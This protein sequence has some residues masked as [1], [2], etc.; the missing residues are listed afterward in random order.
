MTE[1][2]IIS[3]LED[4]DARREDTELSKSL[5]KYFNTSVVDLF[6]D[7]IFSSQSVFLI[8]NVWGR[9][10][11]PER[12]K[13]IYESLSEGNIAYL[14]RFDGKGDQKGKRY[15]IELYKDY[16]HQVVPTYNNV[17][18][19]LT[20][21]FVEYLLKPIYGGSGKGIIHVSAENLTKLFDDQKYLIQ[22]KLDFGSEL[23]LFFVDDTFQYALKTKNERW[24]LE[25]YTPTQDELNTAELFVRWNPIRGIQR[26]D[27][28]KT[29]D[30]HSLLLEIEDWCPYLS[31]GD[32]K[33]IPV[34]QFVKSIAE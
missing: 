29:K 33:N 23:S 5:G 22:P 13:K 1:L 14:N 11:S 12:M 26:I 4:E 2:K 17:V 25:L 3:N 20:C 8:R 9:T 6:D 27:F 30:N 24:D 28:L 32:V 10:D 15:L 7:S 21:G 34:D 19:V 31:L 16:P 18:E